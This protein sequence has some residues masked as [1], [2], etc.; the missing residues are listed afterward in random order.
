MADLANRP[1]QP[2]QLQ[3]GGIAIVMV[4]VICVQCSYVP[5]DMVDAS[6]FM[7]DTCIHT[8]PQCMAVNLRHAIFSNVCFWHIY[9][10][11]CRVDVVAVFWHIHAT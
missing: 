11:K 4:D 9:G 2:M 7:C 5:S 10:K 6:G 3:F 8:H 1:P